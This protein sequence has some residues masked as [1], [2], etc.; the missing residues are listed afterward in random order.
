MNKL[1]KYTG[2]K[3]YMAP[4]GRIMTPEIMYEKSPGAKSVTFVVETDDTGTMMYSFDPLAT[5]RGIYKIDPSLDE[6]AAITAIQKARDAQN[7]KEIL[8]S[9]NERI[10]AALEYQ[11]LLAM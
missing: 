8:P 1:E 5:L 7:N 3:N 9:P 4:S 11:N 6:V 2:T 10:A